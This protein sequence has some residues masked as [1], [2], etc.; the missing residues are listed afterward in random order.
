MRNSTDLPPA[1]KYEA[2]L[3]E[4]VGA[5]REYFSFT[6]MLQARI[7]SEDL[8]GMEAALAKRAELMKGIDRLNAALE[9]ASSR[10]S[11]GLAHLPTGVRERCRILAETTKDLLRKTASLESECVDEIARRRNK[12]QEELRQKSGGMKALHTYA[13]QASFPPRF[14]DVTH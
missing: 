14:K 3:K 1:E 4:K 8:E 6:Q 9:G 5:F 12:I 11:R 7:P 13:P 10:Q 2:L